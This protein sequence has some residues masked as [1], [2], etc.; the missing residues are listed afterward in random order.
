MSNNKLKKLFLKFTCNTAVENRKQFQ[1]ENSGSNYLS[2]ALVYLHI[3]LGALCRF[4]CA[5]IF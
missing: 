5:E 4:Y 3:Q 2:K 1:E